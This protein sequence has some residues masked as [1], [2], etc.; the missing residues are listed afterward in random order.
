MSAVVDGAKKLLGMA[1]P[2]VAQRVEGLRTAVDLS[3]GRL[4]D[5]LVNAA[6]QVAMRPHVH[7]V[8]FGEFAV[9]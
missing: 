4:P 9:V 6:D 1:E 2:T 7:R 5:D 8:P 3:R